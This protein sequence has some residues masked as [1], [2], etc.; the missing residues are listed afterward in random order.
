[1]PD[2]CVQ[3]VTSN[4]TDLY[5]SIK[6]FGVLSNKPTSTHSQSQSLTHN[7]LEPAQIPNRFATP[8]LVA[9]SYVISVRVRACQTSVTARAS[10]AAIASGESVRLMRDLSRPAD[11]LIL[12]TD[13][14][15]SVLQS[16]ETSDD[17]VTRGI[18]Q[19]CNATRAFNYS[20]RMSIIVYA[21]TLA[22]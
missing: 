3:Y 19:A 16:S 8:G 12:T 10:L 11:L 5:S 6:S 1:V 15:L 13:Y 17:A 9:R 20:A 22:V 2:Q 7:T 4:C 21:C 18:C 14:E